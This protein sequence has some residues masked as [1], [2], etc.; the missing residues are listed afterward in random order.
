MSEEVQ[1]DISIAPPVVDEKTATE[2]EQTIEVDAVPKEEED[3]EEYNAYLESMRKEE[4]E[5]R[6]KKI[7]KQEIQVDALF[8]NG[9]SMPVSSQV[10]SDADIS[11]WLNYQTIYEKFASMSY[12][13]RSY[14]RNLTSSEKTN[15]IKGMNANFYFEKDKARMEQ[16]IEYTPSL[17]SIMQKIIAKKPNKNIFNFFPKNEPLG[18]MSYH[19]STEEVL[20]NYP[21]IMDQFLKAMP[22][23]SQDVEII[24]DLFSTIVDE[25]ATAT[26]F[27]GDFSMFLHTIE[28]YESTY[29]IPAYSDDYEEKTE[30]RKITKTRPIF[31][32]IMTSSHSTMSE[33]L[34]NLGVR[35]NFLKKENDHYI[36]TKTEDLGN[37]VIFKNKDVL[38]FTNGLNYL[39]NGSKS[40]FAKQVKKELTRNYFVGNFD[41]AQFM[42]TF[43]VNQN[44]G[45]DQEKMLK[46]SNQFKNIKCNSSNKITDN[47][48]NFE[49]EFNSNFSDKNII[50]QT[51]DLVKFLR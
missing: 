4:L 44:L 34:L 22:L 26:L 1:E 46:F 51:L 38:V 43:L 21:Q 16:T 36:V 3:D 37:V 9:F 14:N 48:M 11:M 50:L 31:T 15:S 6:N 39:N 8:K 47:K 41:I 18:Y 30:E 24:S 42:N 33:K 35:K 29:T 19:S 12:L 40:D 20:K 23:E 2:E 13:F 32:F 5:E 28:Q 17:S 27:D 45:K 7:A 49:M 10:N 25:E